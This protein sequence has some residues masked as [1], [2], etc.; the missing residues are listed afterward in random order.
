M[1]AKFQNMFLPLI[2]MLTFLILVA[3]GMCSI[4]KLDVIKTYLQ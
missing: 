1:L 2:P 3:S 4:S